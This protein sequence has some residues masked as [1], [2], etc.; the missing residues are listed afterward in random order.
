MTN[1]AF[2]GS[3]FGFLLKKKTASLDKINVQYAKY[4]AGTS[5][6]I[7]FTASGS[8]KL[9]SDTLT[10]N[11]VTGGLGYHCTIPSGWPLLYWVD[12]KTG[13]ASYLGL[14]YRSGVDGPDGFSGGYCDGGS[15]IGGTTPTSPETFY[16]GAVDNE[17]PAKPIIVSCTLTSTNQPGNQ[18]V[19][20]FNVTPGTKGKDLQALIAQF[21]ANDVPAF[22]STKFGCGITGR[23]GTKLIIGCGRSVQDTLGWTVVFDPNK[24]DTAPGC[25]GGGAP[26]CVVA[27]GVDVGERAGAVVRRPHEVHFRKDRHSV[28]R[29]KVLCSVLP[30]ATGR[31][32]V[33]L[34]DRVGTVDGVA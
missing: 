24:V 1:V 15:T 31:R 7:D 16:C 25:V 6:Y 3:N 9:C 33:Q 34:D 20:C 8:A 14:F 11:S 13:D 23:Q 28:D 17:A 29:G 19:S 4:T 5:Q 22:D 32:S 18:S 21:T 30:A 27:A 26:G 10:Q 12:H 2:T